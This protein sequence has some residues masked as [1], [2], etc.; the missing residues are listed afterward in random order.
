[1]H[2]RSYALSLGSLARQLR[3]KQSN[4]TRVPC[5]H[6]LWAFHPVS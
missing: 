3:T 2:Q 6:S 1:M 4:A 5:A